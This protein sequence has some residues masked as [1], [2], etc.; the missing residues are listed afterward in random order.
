MVV[1]DQE[2]S[3]AVRIGPIRPIADDETQFFWDG[4]AE[5]RLLILRC[6]DCGNYVHWP[7]PICPKCLSFSLSPAEVSGRG[8]LYSFTV[9][10]QAFHPWFE[11][12]VPYVLAVVELEEQRHL[13]LVSNIV[14]C[15]EEDVEVGMALE[16]V[17]ERVDDALTLPMFRPL[18]GRDEP[19]TP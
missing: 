7:R 1:Q 10:V 19:V 9:A 18:A 14:G 12:R 3:P 6:D 11:T 17:F 13:K 15:R 4:A 5:G 2:R 16:V 8:T